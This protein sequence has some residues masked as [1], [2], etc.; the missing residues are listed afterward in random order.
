MNKILKACF[1][2][3]I[4]CTMSANAQDTIRTKNGETII[5]KVI[6][7][8][9]SNIRYVDFDNQDGPNFSSS[10]SNIESI[11]FKNGRTK[12]FNAPAQQ[13]TSQKPIIRSGNKY[14]CD[15][16]VYRRTDYENFLKNTCPLA[17]KEYTSGRKIAK[18][19]W[20]L[21]GVGV[22]LD[23]CF[24]WWLPYSGIPAL[25]CEIACIPTL[26]VGYKRMHN[27]AEIYNGSCYNKNGQSSYWS[28]NASSYGMGLA[29]NF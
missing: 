23:V 26:I 27:S 9:D 15:G 4:L 17:Q 1:C 8:T 18:A 25:A 22:G 3:I 28:V 11:T 14:I 20:A 16:K 12:E 10:T 24:S 5:A 21:F 7:V 2:G 29:Y 19:G 6:E 13:A